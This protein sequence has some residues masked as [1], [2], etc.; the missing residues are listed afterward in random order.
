MHEYLAR[1][2]FDL[3]SLHLFHL[4]VKHHSFTK[5]AREAGLTQSALTR[6]MQALEQ[7]LGVD[8]LNRTTRSV[9]V[10][11]AGRYLFAES[12]KLLGGVASTL[13]G[14]QTEFASTKPLVRVGLSRTVSGAY[15]PG[16][17]HANRQRLPQVNCA[18]SYL[19]ST[20]IMQGIEQHDIDIGV[21]CIPS[22]LPQTLKVTHRFKD[23]FTLIAHE[24]EGAKPLPT[25]RAEV[26]KWAAKQPWLLIQ[27]VT[28][29][30]KLLHRWMKRQ[31]LAVEP[32][33]EA[34]SFDLIINLVASGLGV[35]FV[36]I[37][38]LALYRRKHSLKLVTLEPRFER[39]LVVVTRR[40]RK[41]PE[42]LTKFIENILF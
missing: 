42:H 40:H 6:Q 33:M 16:F 1:K 17:F 11:E 19:S 30:G 4:V 21:F 7:R 32:L 35:S 26:L 20:E 3:Y 38:A 29:T 37:R 22:K 25:K 27:E 41:V 39:E 36:P 24:P 18:V 13:E 9:A 10:T 15:M 28:T 2:P 5:A 12:A 34:D 8:L 14:L 23:A 31:G